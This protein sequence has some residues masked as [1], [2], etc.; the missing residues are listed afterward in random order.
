M[1]KTLALLLALVLI[2]AMAP[3][4]FATSQST[5]LTTTVPGATYTLNVPKD[6]VIPY[7]STDT[8]IGYVTVTESSGFATGKNLQVTLE[9]SAFTSENASTTIPYTV[10][11][12]P[13][14]KLS[15]TESAET[16]SETKYISPM[17]FNGQ[18]DGTVLRLARDN[19]T[20]TSNGVNYHYYVGDLGVIIYASAWGKAL[21]G[22]Y[23]STI[24]FTASV[25]SAS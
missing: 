6:T 13:T 8:S 23:S 11:Y 10:A 15:D 7:N 22:D 19:D 24:T 5:K 12:S 2:V 21:A 3:A 25:V 1:K 18:N 17:T 4:A 16:H 20:Y 9:Y 14:K